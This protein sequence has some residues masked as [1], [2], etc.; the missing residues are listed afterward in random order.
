MNPVNALVAFYDI[1]GR[2]GILLFC[3]GHHTRL[4]IRYQQ[5]NP[6]CI[7]VKVYGVFSYVFVFVMKT[8]TLTRELAEDDDKVVI[9]I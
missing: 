6:R 2:K 9:A 1:C 7:R 8:C 3:P 4:K 5:G